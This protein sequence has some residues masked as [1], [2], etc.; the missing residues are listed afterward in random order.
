MRRSIDVGPCGVGEVCG[1]FADDK[2]VHLQPLS[3]R[4]AAPPAPV[5]PSA[6]D[7]FAT[8]PRICHCMRS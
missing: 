3:S 7:L 2:S 6:N 4:C 5:C 8:W 1:M